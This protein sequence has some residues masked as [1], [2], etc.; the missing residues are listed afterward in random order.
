MTVECGADDIPPSFIRPAVLRFTTAQPLK[1][2][3]DEKHYIEALRP[4]LVSAGF[5][6]NF[7][8]DQG[9]SGVQEIRNEWG[10]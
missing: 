1:P 6:G 10:E 8:V 5:P 7:L 9:R 3:T 2:L 4:L